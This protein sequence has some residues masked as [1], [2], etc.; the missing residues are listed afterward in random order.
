MKNMDEKAVKILSKKNGQTLVTVMILAAALSIM[1]VSL[2]FLFQYNQ[3]FLVRASCIQQ[4]QELAS[5]ALEQCI[6][7]LEQSN[8]W[9]TFAST[10]TNY[11]NYSNTFTSSMGTYQTHIVPGN[12][13]LTKISDP[14]QPRQD[15]N[16][17]RTIGIRVTTAIT[18]CSG[19]FYAVI[20]KVGLGGPLISK[21]YIDTCYD[22]NGSDSDP[23]QFFWGD[24]YSANTQDAY[25]RIRQIQVAGGS[26]VNGHQPWLPQVFAMG[27]IYTAVSYNSGRA[28]TTFIFAQTYDDMSPSAHSH[29]YSTLAAAPDI[30]FDYF[31]NYAKARGTY[32]GPTGKA[33]SQVTQANV[34]AIM[35]LAN[36]PGAVLF[37]DT[38][39]GLPERTSPCNTYCGTTYTSA[40]TIAFYTS[41]AQQY[42]T[43]GT[44]IVMGPLRLVGDNP[45]QGESAHYTTYTPTTQDYYDY[46]YNV[47][48][49]SNFYLPQ[50]ADGLHFTPNY[51]SNVKHYGFL[52]T[53]GDLTIGG[54]RSGSPTPNS[55]ICIYG[56]VYLGEY[57]RLWLDTAHDTPS[58]Y[59]Y[60]NSGSNLFGVTGST[61]QI[62]S[63]SE[64]TFLIPTPVPSY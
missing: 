50:S 46:V 58:L 9:Y 24:I 55:N 11:L 47:T 23:A 44:V 54:T 51:L 63:F 3:K 64:F 22:T 16:N 30:D 43:Y 5:L 52:Y 57:G 12:L 31:R 26:V 45:S 19:D 38:T 59:V 41:N 28:G 34:A 32:Y 40:N 4:K 7:K 49:P 6:Y 8:N 61:V 13:F 21:G 53:N 36:G 62:I 56:T 17:S 39:D 48:A 18:S 20:Q 1:S 37:I 10:M 42:F 33:I 15:L 14:T 2:M 60:Y 27:S 29:P 25:C 35:G